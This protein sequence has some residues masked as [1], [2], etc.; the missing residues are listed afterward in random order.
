MEYN[1]CKLG[2]MENSRGSSHSGVVCRTSFF[3]SRRFGA[4]FFET[5]GRF[6]RVLAHEESKDYHKYTICR[7]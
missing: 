4:G 6:R 7:V 3:S 2:G 1:W 5:G